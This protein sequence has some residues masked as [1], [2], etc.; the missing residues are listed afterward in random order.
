[1]GC[2]IGTIKRNTPI[3]HYF[4]LLKNNIILQ[5][6]IFFLTLIQSYGNSWDRKDSSWKLVKSVLF[7]FN[8][9]N[10]FFHEEQHLKYNQK[11]IQIGDKQWKS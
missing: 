2:L 9:S 4:I 10:H 1:M 11:D 7:L 6:E 8:K 5:V 3:S